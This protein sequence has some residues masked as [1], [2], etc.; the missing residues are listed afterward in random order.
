[1][2]EALI[3]FID[4]IHLD[5][6]GLFITGLSWILMFWMYK[7]H[8]SQKLDWSELVTAKNGNK[9]SL[10]KFLQLVGGVTGTWIVIYTTL[11]NKLTYDILLVYLTYVGAIDGWSKFVSA[12]YGVLPAPREETKG[13]SPKEENPKKDIKTITSE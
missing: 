7:A 5:V 9:V 10:T 4:S 12:K 1:M 11:H 8:R 2:K 6:G 13:D 3:T